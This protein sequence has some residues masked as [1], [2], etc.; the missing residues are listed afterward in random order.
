MWLAV[1]IFVYLAVEVLSYITGG[2]E[3]PSNGRKADIKDYGF[4]NGSKRSPEAA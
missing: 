4:E 2:A 1:I 3:M